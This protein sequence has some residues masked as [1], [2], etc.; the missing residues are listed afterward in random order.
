MR[1]ARLGV[2]FVAALS[3]EAATGTARLALEGGH[4]AGV[5]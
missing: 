5:F 1:Q 2:P 4:Q 3:E